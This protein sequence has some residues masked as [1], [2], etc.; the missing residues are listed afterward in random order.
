MA[1]HLHNAHSCEL[2]Q[3]TLLIYQQTTKMRSLGQELVKIYK[4]Q[5]FHLLYSA[6]PLYQEVINLTYC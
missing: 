3:T 5:N 1:T 6:W 2:K 4:T